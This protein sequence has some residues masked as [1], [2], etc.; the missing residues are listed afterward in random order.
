M[1]R[2]HLSCIAFIILTYQSIFI[3]SRGKKV[4][5]LWI[6]NLQLPYSRFMKGNINNCSMHYQEAAGSSVVHHQLIDAAWC[7]RL[8]SAS[9]CV[10]PRVLAGMPF[11]YYFN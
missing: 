9:H 11:S 3:I 6:I 10:D 7:A 5:I 1:L 4:G 2:E 8:R